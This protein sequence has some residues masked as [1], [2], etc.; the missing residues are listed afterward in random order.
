MSVTLVGAG[1]GDAGY[2]TLRGVERIKQADVVLYDRFVSDDI[3]AMIPEAAEQI[4]VGKHVGNHPVP[5]HQINQILLEKAQMGLEVVRLKGGDPFVFGRG[6]EELELLAEH[7]IPFEVVPGISSAIAGPAAAGIPVTH[8][9]FASSVHIITGHAK[10]DASPDINF[11]ALVE[12]GGTLVF[13]MGVSAIADICQG[14]LTAGMDGGM[15]AA[16]IEHAT[17]N[18]QRKFLGTVATLPDLAHQNNVQAPSL[19]VIGKVCLLSERYDWFS[20]RPL[21][22]LRVA[23]ARSSKKA[24]QLTG[25]LRELGCQVF[26]LPPPKTVALTDPGCLLEKAMAEIGQFAWLAFTSATGVE[27]FF[28]YLQA[29]NIDIR[30]L[31]HL[32][33]ATVGIETERELNRRGIQAD[34]C[35][36]EFNGTA[37]AAGLS[38]LV[39]GGEKVLLARAKDGA[40]DIARVLA[41]R[42]VLFEDVAIYEKLRSRQLSNSQRPGNA[43]SQRLGDTLPAVPE[44]G[45]WKQIGS[46]MEGSL[47]DELAAGRI[48]Y[49][50]FTSASAVEAFVDLVS[51]SA[52]DIASAAAAAAA[53]GGVTAAPSAAAAG[54]AARGVSAAAAGSSP[55]AFDFGSIQAVCIGP[56]TAA[57]ASAH[58]MVVHVSKAA[59]IT[60]LVEAIERLGA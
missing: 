5:Q 59:S 54:A 20:T 30:S 3:L 27:V 32:K 35:P 52:G 19:I 55:S 24:S 17:T 39:K 56:T 51:A 33:V 48:D 45:R 23:V 25:R 60:S 42:G 18:I 40:R 44:Q 31:H 12:A 1:P 58:G 41:E 49:V 13:L 46:D 9:D 50:A 43:E 14:C 38:A 28:D 34:Y 15:P 57:A 21:I 6:G 29:C 4:N 16:I 8:R 26:E 47:L 2:L 37:L 36:Q 22:G 10:N 7:G 11:S 53:T